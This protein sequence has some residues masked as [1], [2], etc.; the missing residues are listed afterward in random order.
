MDIADAA[1]WGYPGTVSPPDSSTVCGVT[2]CGTAHR[3]EDK[4][5]RIV[6]W[7]MWVCGIHAS[8]MDTA[9]LLSLSS[10][11]SLPYRPPQPQRGRETKVA[12]GKNKKKGT[13]RKGPT[14]AARGVTIEDLTFMGAVV[15]IHKKMKEEMVRFTERKEKAKE[16]EKEK[17]QL[18]RAMR[19]ER[20]FAVVKAARLERENE[21]G[22]MEGQVA[23]WRQ[24][25]EKAEAKCVDVQRCARDAIAGF[26][27]ET[28]AAKAKQ[29]GFVQELQRRM[30]IGGI[31]MYNIERGNEG[32]FVP[33]NQ[34]HVQLKAWEEQQ[35]ESWKEIGELKEKLLKAVVMIRE[36]KGNLSHMEC[37]AAALEQA[38]RAISIKGKKEKEQLVVKV[39]TEKR[40]TERMASKWQKEREKA[41]ADTKTTREAV[42]TAAAETNSIEAALAAAKLH[43]QDSSRRHE[44]QVKVL[45]RINDSR[46]AGLEKF[47]L[48]AS[49]AQGQ[50]H[51]NQTKDWSKVSA[52][53]SL[54]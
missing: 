36:T 44:D 49:R 29:H 33:K 30:E 20:D 22:G 11:P 53:Q 43:L 14:A 46:L 34:M 38:V 7:G 51:K 2:G 12:V 25:A 32:L 39:A 21:R 50:K 40:K 16:K 26:E 35:E 10:S 41:A 37:H 3:K 17:D 48:Q 27:A 54:H 15:E 13:G 6:L 18:V 45:R 42:E 9:L 47:R 5:G 31:Q 28:R 4:G 23:G 8:A 1:T 24:R 19:G 52:F